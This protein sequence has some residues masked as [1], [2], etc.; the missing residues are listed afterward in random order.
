MSS[1]RETYPSK[2]VYDLSQFAEANFQRHRRPR[3]IMV[4][5]ASLS[6][7]GMATFLLYAIYAAPSFEKIAAVVIGVTG[8]FVSYM[9]LSLMELPIKYWGKPPDRVVI[10]DLGIEFATGAEVPR[11]VLWSDVGVRVNLLIRAPGSGVPDSARVRV[12]VV[13]EEETG[14]IWRRL[15]PITYV[16]EKAALEILGFARG[17]GCRIEENE[18]KHVMSLVPHTPCQVYSIFGTPRFTTARSS[19]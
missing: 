3:L 7:L 19:G 1:A 12:T 13:K 4:A 14:R 2:S 18:S 6:A 9:L 10:S 15:I 16:P 17:A 11:A 8:I 5:V